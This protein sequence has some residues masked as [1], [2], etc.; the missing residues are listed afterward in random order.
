MT[1]VY[2]LTQLAGDIHQRLAD[3]EVKRLRAQLQVQ[4]A[5]DQ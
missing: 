3:A 4:A 5:S 1:A 2:Q